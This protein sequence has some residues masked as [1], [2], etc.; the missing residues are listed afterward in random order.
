MPRARP[1]GGGVP[2][3]AFCAARSSTPRCRGWLAEQRA[4]ELVGILAGGVRQ[5]VDEALDDEAGVGVAD[6]APPEHRHRRPSGCGASTAMVRAWRR[7]DPAAPSTEVASMPSLTIAASNGVPVGDRL[8]DDRVLPGDRLAA[9]V[10]PGADGRVPHRPV[11]AAADVVLAR[12]DHL[13]R[14][15]AGGLGDVHGL[16]D[17]V[18]ARRRRAG[19]SRR[20]G[21]ACGSRPARA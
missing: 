1:G 18:G 4:A 20:R 15:A 5:L 8:A 3:P 17:E 9:R 10:E 21:R 16:D 19:R 6:R 2:Q 7:E 14:R 11:V 13:D 12:P